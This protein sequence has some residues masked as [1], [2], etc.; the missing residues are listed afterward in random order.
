MFMYSVYESRPYSK[1]KNKQTNNDNNLSWNACMWLKS[2]YYKIQGG[3]G[4]VNKNYAHFQVVDV[5]F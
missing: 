3:G 2:V 5:A 4:V 1:N